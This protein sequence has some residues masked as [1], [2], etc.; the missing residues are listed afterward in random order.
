VL[1]PSVLALLSDIPRE[2]FV[3]PGRESLA[4]ADLELPIGHGEVMLAPK[5]QARIAQEVALRPGDRVLEI[6]TG[7]GY[8]TA[9]L[10]RLAS[11]VTSIE[12]HEDLAAGARARLEALSVDNTQVITGN[13][14]RG[15]SAAAPFD[16]IVITGSLPILPEAFR[17]S[18]AVGGRLFAVIGEAPVMSAVLVT[19]E[20]DD[21]W[22]STPL[23]ETVIPPLHHAEQP[24]RFVF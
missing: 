22:V 18:L 7:T 13:A 20:S 10:A 19:R 15:W 8:L 3:P 17:R 9:L 4:F 24:P 11:H 21:A 2:R 23:F 6:G 1:D 16:A 14:A 5:L 12:L